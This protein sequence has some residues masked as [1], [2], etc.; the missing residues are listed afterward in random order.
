MHWNPLIEQWLAALRAA[1]R[2]PSTLELRRH[3]L[4]RFARDHRAGPASVTADDVAEWVGRES[5]ALET[6][7]SH[8][9]ALSTFYGWAVRTGRLEHDPTAGLLPAMPAHHLPRPAAED[10]VADALATTRD[11]RVR[12]MVA[13]A[14]HAGLRRAEVAA[15]RREDM[16]EGMG[17]WVLRVHGKGGRWR[18]VPLPGWLADVIRRR[19][20]GWLFPGNDA[21]HLSP[22][23]TGRLMGRVLPA[24]VTPH[25]LRHRYASRVYAGSRDLLATQQLLGHA[26]PETTRGYVALS[27]ESLRAAANHAA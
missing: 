27:D 16:V 15:A 26:R 12:M 19:P 1:G 5:W 10:V 17:G 3:Q 18:L 6:R 21:G 8:R 2:P 22:A 7:R 24:G 20:P 4:G 11:E 25:Q 23:W 9:A 13:L 14:A